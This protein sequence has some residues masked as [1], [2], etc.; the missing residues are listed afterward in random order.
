MA[1]PHRPITPLSW[2]IL[3]KMKK[4]FSFFVLNNKIHRTPDYKQRTIKDI[5]R[6]FSPIFPWMN[7]GCLQN[8]VT[9][10]CKLMQKKIS[11]EK[12]LAK[13]SSNS[14]TTY[15]LK[16]NHHSTPM[17]YTSTK[18][19]VKFVTP[20]MYSCIWISFSVHKLHSSG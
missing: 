12:R 15:P 19:K 7:Q 14:I 13:K 5:V 2:Q 17:L 4:I 16:V 11:A 18:S 8:Y 6:L 20:G 10:H 3:P 1:E 9:K